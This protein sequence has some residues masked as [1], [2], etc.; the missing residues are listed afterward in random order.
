MLWRWVWRLSKLSLR[1]MG[2]GG[3]FHPFQ[4]CELMSHC[5]I[6]FQKCIPSLCRKI[7]IRSVTGWLLIDRFPIILSASILTLLPPLGTLEVFWAKKGINFL[8]SF[9]TFELFLADISQSKSC[10]LGLL[11]YLAS[12]TLF[13]HVSC[14]PISLHTILPPKAKFESLGD[15]ILSPPQCW[16]WITCFQLTLRCKLLLPLSLGK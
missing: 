12:S 6:L 13:H 10:Y 14:S 15:L 16:P 11:R 3:K 1:S 5:E 7:R 2:M 4:I 9:Q 8:H